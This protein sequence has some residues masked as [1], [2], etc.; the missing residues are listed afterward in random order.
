MSAFF[1]SVISPF[2][3]PLQASESCQS[4]LKKEKVSVRYVYDGDT[5]QLS[6]RRRV[7][8]VGLNTPELKEGSSWS[9]SVAVDAKSTLEQW[10]SLR[11]NVYLQIEQDA[12]DDYGRVLGYMVDDKGEDPAVT[13]LERGLA[14]AVVIAPNTEKQRCYFAI[15]RKARQAGVGVWAHVVT[16]AKNLTKNT[17]F[18][19]VQG[20][21]T[22][23]FHFKTSEAIVLDDNL[24]VMLR[25]VS[26]LPSLSGKEVRI[27]GWV[28]DRAFT[29]KDFSA[30][31]TVYLNHKA[32]VEVL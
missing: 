17:G 27:R 21:V 10:L 30:R 31:F 28:Q 2:I 7:R 3:S 14:Y 18:A 9:R 1:V 25:G 16:R 29:R 22:R 20:K 19:L 32:N 12:R 13:L 4:A 11:P 6:D 26:R 24:V 5:L 8:L 15:E 23:Q